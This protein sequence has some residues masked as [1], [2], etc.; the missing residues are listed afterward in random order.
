M[1]K[2]AAVAQTV[3]MASDTFFFLS[4]PLLVLPGIYRDDSKCVFKPSVQGYF[5]KQADYAFVILENLDTSMVKQ[6]LFP[7]VAV[8]GSFM[9]TF[10]DGV[11]DAS[12]R[13]AQHPSA[14]FSILPTTRLT[15]VCFPD[16]TPLIFRLYLLS[17]QNSTR[18]PL[19]I[20]Y[21]E[22]LSLRVF[23]E[24][25]YISP[26][27]SSFSRNEGAGTNYFSFEDNLLYV[28]LHEEEPVE[29]VTGLSLHVAFTVTET[30]GEEGEANIMHQLADFL[31][32]GHDQVRIVY[33]VPGGESMLE[34]I[35][36]N[37][38]KK[39]YHCPNMTFCTIF[40][41]RS[42][43]RGRGRATVNARVVQSSDAAGPSK[44]LIFE[45]GDPPGHQINEF[46]RSLTTDSLKILAS[47]II[48]AHQTGDLQTVLGLPV[49]TIMV[50]QPDLLFSGRDNR[51]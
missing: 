51:R 27:P 38:S 46:Q 48:N 33:R 49:D 24:G 7:V 42:G 3:E 16:L 19:A 9:D 26:T 5:C 39:K 10:S 6:E 20:F 47:A 30:T 17:G 14:L 12:C 29:I 40:H 11:S 43:S 8:T 18:L 28:L 34:V 41:S 4:P 32:V 25:K 21:N 2:Y 37:A 22:P 13:S 23:T 15:T 44:V 31:Q 35:S 45:F 50:N 36:D 1:G